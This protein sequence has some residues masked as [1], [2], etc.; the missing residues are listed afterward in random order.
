[1]N[2]LLSVFLI[3]LS[4]VSASPRAHAAAIAG[5]LEPTQIL[6][7]IEL[8]GVN[9]SDAATAINTQL[10]QIKSTIL[11]PLGNS[12]IAL[13]QLQ[14]ANGIIS[15]VNGGTGGVSLIPGDTRKYVDLKGLEAVKI[16]LGVLGSQQNGA[17]SNTL[18]GSL[19]Q[20]FKSVP[21]TTQLSQLNQSSI[22]KTVQAAACDD[23]TLSNLAREDVEVEGQPLD[24]AAYTAR[25]AY[26]YEQ[27]CSKDANDPA[28]AQALNQ[29]SSARPGIAMWDKWLE[30]TVGGENEYTKTVRAN[31]IVAEEMA[32]RA[33]EASKDLDRGRGVASQKEC[34]VR[35]PS[36]INGEPYATPESAPCI[37]D[38][39]LNPS[40]LLQDSLTK[41]AN[42]GLE[43]LGNI[44]GWGS[45]ITTLASIKQ[46]SDGIRSVTGSL[47]TVVNSVDGGSSSGGSNTS[48][49]NTVTSA[50]VNDLA[51]DAEKKATIVDP[52]KALLDSDTKLLADLRSVD[53]S[54]LSDIS[55]YEARLQEVKMCYADIGANDADSLFANRE[56]VMAELRAK[57]ADDTA[58]ITAATAQIQNM[59]NLLQT[60][61]ST[62]QIMD[63]FFAYQNSSNTRPSYAT[64]AERRADYTKNKSNA[65]SDLSGNGE[66][67]RAHNSCTTRKNQMNQ[68]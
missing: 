44:Q 28:T 31:Q 42:A 62:K 66:L 65:T 48:Y 33:E 27:F 47:S 64:L 18:L 41:A 22:P 23:T 24:Q 51:N 63:A 1:M 21:F 3:T 25:K 67:T 4:F 37:S 53:Q 17:Y 10:L 35:A 20:N 29:L 14:T 43:R 15:L 6:N 30:T 34:L 12:L 8:V 45:L 7:N 61:Q 13:S 11:D 68:Y 5:A 56:G 32:R 50:P 57:V 36:D 49:S 59:R 39:V 60:S 38:V 40:G 55:A 2:Y 19:T 9:I 58:K 46:L 26:F 52:I 54:I 16:S